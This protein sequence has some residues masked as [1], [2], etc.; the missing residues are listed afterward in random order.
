[1]TDEDA[2]P[3]IFRD[4]DSSPEM[5]IVPPGDFFMGSP[6]QEP[7]RLDHEGPRHRVEIARPFALGRYPVTFR[8]FDLFVTATNQA[9]WPND[10]GWG[11]ENRPVI[12]VTP[13]ESL[14][15]CDWLTRLTGARYHLPSEAQWEYACRAG[16]TAA[17]STGDKL[18]TELANVSGRYPHGYG[19]VGPSLERTTPVGSYPPNPFGLHDMHGNVWERCADHW[20]FD[21]YICHG[22]YPDAYIRTDGGG[23]RV[24]RGGSYDLG[25]RSAR[26]A[27]RTYEDGNE[28]WRIAGR[29]FRVAR[30]LKGN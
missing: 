11:R 17:F 5:V 15:Y 20:H 12:G 13:I 9:A 25:Y 8:E 21:A 27:A 3:K 16:T 29:G 19:P 26:S 30:V 14:A 22:A 24:L 2:Q 10:R 6:E 23:D 28:A 18:S 1:M 4:T 7:H